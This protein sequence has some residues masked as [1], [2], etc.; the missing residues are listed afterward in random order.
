[1]DPILHNSTGRHCSVPCRYVG[2]IFHSFHTKCGFLLR[3]YRHFSENSD[4]LQVLEYLF[5]AK[6]YFSANNFVPLCPRNRT[7]AC[8]LGYTR[9]DNQRIKSNI[10]GH[11]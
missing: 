9:D 5:Q 2:S 11:N 1:M 8:P 3:F 7:D 10:L 4:I 6:K